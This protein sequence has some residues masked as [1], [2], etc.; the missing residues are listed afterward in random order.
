VVGRRS[1]R[2]GHA[3][4]STDGQVAHDAD[5]L[6]S[7]RVRRAAAA[8]A[9]RSVGTAS[10]VPKYI[11]SGVCPRN[12]DVYWIPIYEILDARG[13]EVYLV[14]A[15]DTKNLPGRKTDVPG[16]ASLSRGRPCRLDDENSHAKVLNVC[17]IAR[18]T[19]V[20]LQSFV[21]VERDQSTDGGEAVQRVEE[22]PLMF[23]GAP[24]RFD[25]GVENFSSVS[26]P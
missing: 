20:A 14:N 26:V 15:R 23:Q 6:A 3:A 5:R 2:L 18:V 13:F 12:A 16:S 8:R 21:N 19:T 1:A 11:S 25:H 7:P 17:A 9:V 4:A 10:P 22:E 24:P